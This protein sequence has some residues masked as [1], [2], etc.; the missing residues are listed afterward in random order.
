MFTLKSFIGQFKKEWVLFRAWLYVGIFLGI[1]ISIVIPYLIERYGNG[2]TEENQLQF[3]FT[4]L[5]LALGGFYSV[6]QFVASLRLDLRSKEIWLHSTSSI[7]QLIGVKIVFS[8]TGYTIFN[9]LFTGIAIY[10]LR[11]AFIASF[12][13][14]LLLL[15]FVVAIIALFQL[16]IFVSILLFLAF[17][18]QMK[19]FI[20]RFAIVLMMG[21]YFGCIYLW[22]RFTESIIYVKIF[23]HIGIS[24]SWLE[25]YLPKSKLPSMD[26][27][28]G[29]LYV[30]EE[31]ALTILFALL[32]IIATKW[33][34]KVVLR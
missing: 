27:R 20:G 22:F 3:A 33:L 16:M 19:Y 32:F 26:I 23:Q 24:L 1:L 13:Q 29:T 34:E 2:F 4:F 15:V 12:G 25:Q 9:I 31:L 17:Y 10:S 6:L 5:V 11:A 28:L 7:R 14:V 18:L 30:V 8:L 21:A